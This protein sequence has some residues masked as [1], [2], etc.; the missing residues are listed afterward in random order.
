MCSV[1]SSHSKIIFCRKIHMNTLCMQ[2]KF[3]AAISLLQACRKG[4]AITCTGYV[5]TSIQLYSVDN[6]V[7]AHVIKL[8]S[9]VS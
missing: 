6:L 1:R 9:V 5:V 3:I 2:L 4:H 7:I 8:I